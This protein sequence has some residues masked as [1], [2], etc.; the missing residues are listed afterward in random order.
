MSEE[1][2][3]AEEESTRCLLRTHDLTLSYGSVRAVDQL[4]LNVHEGEIYGFLGRNGAGKTSTIRMIMGITK[5]DH[6]TIEFGGNSLK[7]I[8]VREKQ[9]IG[10]VSQEQHMYPWMT[11]K[12]IGE[13][14]GGLFPT[15]DAAE[16]DRLIS[17]LDLPPKRKVSHL[18]GGMRVKLALALALSHRPP[19]LVLDEPTAG[20]DPVA[21]REFLEIISHQARQSN[22]TTF[23]SSHL[24]DEVE[25]V[26][27]RVGVIHHGKLEFEGSLDRLG[28]EVRQVV[29]PSEDPE[30]ID[31]VKQLAS[32]ANLR[33]LRKG[34][35][36]SNSLVL[37]GTEESWATCAIESSRIETVSLEDAF[38]ALAS[39]DAKL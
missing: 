29:L 33:Y 16:F 8:R 24:I 28:L 21:R 12:R 39:E 15:W 3:V 9:S 7:R 5:P 4:S 1:P 27:D 26:A 19:I 18:S 17:V 6:G 22:R 2:L 32:D 38:I 35:G 20:L 31:R 13:F 25:R 10:Y 34:L 37:H 14:V 11:C 30:E 36:K 23:F